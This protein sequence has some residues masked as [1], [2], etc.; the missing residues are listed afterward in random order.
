MVK[1]KE[2]TPS[3]AAPKKTAKMVAK[4]SSQQPLYKVDWKSIVRKLPGFPK[5]LPTA[6]W[7]PVLEELYGRRVKSTKDVYKKCR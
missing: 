1:T 5:E 7:K 6:K 2:S 4:T 3:K